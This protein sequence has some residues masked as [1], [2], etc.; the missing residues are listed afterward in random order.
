MS[1]GVDRVPFDQIPD[2]VAVASNAG[3]YAEPMAEH[4]LALA[5]ALAKR[6]PQE[7][8]AL[9]RGVF[10]QETPTLS[11]RGSLVGIIGFG[12]IGQ[13]SARL[14]QALGAHVHAINRSGRT[15]A[16]VDQIGTMEDL[17]AL[18]CSAR[19]TSWSSRSR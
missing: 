12:G 14:F 5:L 19:P 4:V 7:H 16:P 2:G 15:D 17:A 9:A 11:I 18:L 3:A 10:D 8:A 1:A 6:L 13:A